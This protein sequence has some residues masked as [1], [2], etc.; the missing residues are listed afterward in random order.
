MKREMGNQM[1]CKTEEMW[2]RVC[3]AWY[4][5]ALNVPVELNNSLPRRITDLIEAKGGATKY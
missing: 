3:E 2:T 4:S 1:P 5:V